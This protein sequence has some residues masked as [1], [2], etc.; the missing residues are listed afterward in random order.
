MKLHRFARA[1]AWTLL[2]KISAIL[3]SLSEA[4]T[5]L[6]AAAHLLYFNIFLITRPTFDVFLISKQTDM[7]NI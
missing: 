2:G 3:L 7:V 1:V 5:L 4:S 6:V